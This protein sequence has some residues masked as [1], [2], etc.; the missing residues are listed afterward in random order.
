MNRPMI[1]DNGVI[2]PMSDE[3]IAALERQAAQIPPP[4]PTPEERIARLEE[5]NAHLIEALELILSGAT[6]VTVDG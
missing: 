6:E 3:E 2:R 4:E 5:E 1:D